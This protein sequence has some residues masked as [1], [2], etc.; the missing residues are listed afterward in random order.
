M[1]GRVL[2]VVREPAQ[3]T[4]LLSLAAEHKAVSTKID[5]MQLVRTISFPSSSSLCTIVQQLETFLAQQATLQASIN[6]L[7]PLVL[8]T[9]KLST[10][11]GSFESATANA[12]ANLDDLLV[13]IA[14]NLNDI[15]H[16][17]DIERDTNT[18]TS[19][20]RH[21]SILPPPSPEFPPFKRRK[22]DLTPS[23]PEVIPGSQP[24]GVDENDSVDRPTSP[25]LS[26]TRSSNA[27]PLLCPTPFTP[28]QA[29]YKLSSVIS[30]VPTPCPLEK[31]K[32]KPA[33]SHSPR[34]LKS[35]SI[36]VNSLQS[37]D[38]TEHPRVLFPPPPQFPPVRAVDDRRT[39]PYQVGTS[40]TVLDNSFWTYYPPTSQVPNLSPR[41]S[42]LFA[43]VESLNTVQPK[44]PTATLAFHSPV[45]PP[46]M[47]TNLKPKPT[48]R[49]IK[50]DSDGEDSQSGMM[51]QTC[52]N[53][54]A[55]L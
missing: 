33:Q 8:A 51:G 54:L 50:L 34:S 2:E 43:S 52:I 27:P 16:H 3:E 49:T 21:S 40:H 19:K 32:A 6:A 7:Q 23:S 29:E 11:L 48:R 24:N 14:A 46:Y 31:Q 36:V 55:E 39:T 30:P 13:E 15:K 1:Q 28:T 44:L 22:F 38:T 4:T 25:S 41:Q 9:E 17:R 37:V 12:L 47:Q 20:K 42:P 5:L 35:T 53:M 10:R 18:N 26:A 45:I